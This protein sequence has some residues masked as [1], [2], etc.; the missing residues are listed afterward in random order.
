V[1]PAI[2]YL[3]SDAAASITGRVIGATGN[4]ITMWREPSWDRSIYTQQP[5]WDIDTVFDLMP[6]TLSVGGLGPPPSQGP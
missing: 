5:Y 4:S 1:V 3:A 6:Q 2:V